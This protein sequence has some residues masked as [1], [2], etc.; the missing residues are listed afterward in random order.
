MTDTLRAALYSIPADCDRATWWNIAA[1]LKTE[2]GE[3]GFALFDSW[4][5]AAPD[6]YD[7]STTASTWRSV[8]AGYFTIGTV[9]HLARENGWQGQEPVRRE[10]TPEE[11]RQHAEVR[12][13]E[14]QRELEREQEAAERGESLI[15]NAT[16]GEHP[17]LTQKGFPEE[18]GFVQQGNHYL[19]DKLVIADGDLLIPMRCHTNGCIKSIQ[20]INA[21][22]QKKFYPGGA[23][24]ATV[25][26]IGPRSSLTTWYCEGYV[27]ALSVRAALRHLYREDQVVCCFMASNLPK[28]AQRDGFVVADHDWWRCPKKECRAK[29]DYES[30]RCPSCGSSGVTEPAGEKH[31]KQTGLPYW[32][33]HEPGTDANDVMLS[34]GVEA[35]ADVI[36]DVHMTAIPWRKV[37]A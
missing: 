9:Y 33:P 24:G 28:V 13:R 34:H 5:Q 14:R 17:Y 23:A 19:G 2:M 29:W 6:K 26:R 20:S 1:A 36:R 7:R 3:A 21:D 25:F 37:V 30:K 10:P 35:L 8:H 32:M 4:S 12:R 16:Y 27:T 15:G 22:G 11:R 18:Y 31:A